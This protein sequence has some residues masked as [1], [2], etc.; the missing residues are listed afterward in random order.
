MHSNHWHSNKNSL[1]NWLSL[2]T[3]QLILYREKWVYID[4]VFNNNR[5]RRNINNILSDLLMFYQTWLLVLIQII[6]LIK[7][8]C[9]I[10]FLC[11]KTSTIKLTHSTI[12]SEEICWSDARIMHMLW[13]LDVIML[14]LWWTISLQKLHMILW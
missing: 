6:V 10:Y 2:P 12:C 11:V 9:D 1:A 14:E 4:V 3:E 7:G 8:K 5:N 13:P